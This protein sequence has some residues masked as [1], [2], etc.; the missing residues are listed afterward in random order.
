MSSREDCL[1][2][3]PRFALFSGLP[4]QTL[5]C[6]ADVARVIPIQRNETLFSV[7]DDAKDVFGIISGSVRIILYSSQGHPVTFARLNAGEI[8]GELS[9]IDGEARSASA[10]AAENCLLLA[11]PAA[12]FKRLLDEDRSFSNALLRRLSMQIR[13]LS[14]RVYEFSTLAVQQRVDAELL[15]LARNAMV[16]PNEALLKPA[17]SLVE[18]ASRIST[19]REAV[20]R[21]ISNLVHA[22]IVERDSGA[23]R[24]CDVERLSSIVAEAQGE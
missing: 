7:G 14:A 6:L 2:A 23:L 13:R 22:G 8:F 16:G 10:E 21:E 24:I 3:I 17:P 5:G 9:V 4:P 15:R 11:I 1:A 20:S 18:I 12:E 19:H